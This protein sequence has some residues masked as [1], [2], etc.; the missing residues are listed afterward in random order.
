MSYSKTINKLTFNDTPQTTEVISSVIEFN[1]EKSS[2]GYIVSKQERRSELEKAQDNTNAILL[3]NQKAQEKILKDIENLGWKLE[4]RELIEGNE[5]EQR[6]YRYVFA[7]LI[8]DD[9]GS[10]TEIWDGVSGG[11]GQF[12]NT[13][14]VGWSD[15]DLVYMNGERIPDE[16]MSNEL[17]RNQTPN[18]WLSSYMNVV[19][20]HQKVLYKKK[21][22]EEAKQRGEQGIGMGM[23]TESVQLQ[24]LQAMQAQ[25]AASPLVYPLSPEYTSNLSPG[26]SSIFSP[27]PG[28]SPVVGAQMAQVQQPVSFGQAVMSLQGQPKVVMPNPLVPVMVAPA[29]PAQAQTEA[30]GIL[31]VEK[32]TEDK[33]SEGDKSPKKT[34]MVNL[35]Q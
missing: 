26:Y 29:G 20:E 19:S 16:I 2:V 6:R 1:K 24:P 8:L 31:S 14:P 32:K 25:D 11:Y 17:A 4:S 3:D 35:G 21:L 23:S 13:H 18:N 27:I 30:Q 15:K 7:S 5:G 22:L 9:R 33:E 12:P 28:T 34:V 10:P